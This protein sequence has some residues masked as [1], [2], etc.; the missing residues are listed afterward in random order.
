MENSGNSIDWK[1]GRHWLVL[2]LVIVPLR[3]LMF[4]R[5]LVVKV[6]RKVK[7]CLRP[8]MSGTVIELGKRAYGFGGHSDSR[9]PGRLLDVQ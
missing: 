7:M 9:V 4:G 2:T 5:T 3:A 1:N 8:L 6:I